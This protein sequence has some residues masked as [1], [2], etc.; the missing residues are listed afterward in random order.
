MSYTLLN[1]RTVKSRKGRRCIWCPEPINTGDTATVESSVFEGEFQYH[2]WH[3]ECWKAS[4]EY[5]KI[6]SEPEFFPHEN[7]RGSAEEHA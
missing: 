2:H 7:K 3:P 5:F 6:N 1:Q 4:Q